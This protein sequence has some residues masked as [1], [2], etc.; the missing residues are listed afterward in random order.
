MAYPRC[1]A[2]HHKRMRTTNL[3]ERSFLEERRRARTIPRFL[4]ENNCG[5]RVFATLWRASERWQGVC[6]SELERQQLKLL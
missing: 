2:V 3:L 5:K 4:S 6:M 1:P